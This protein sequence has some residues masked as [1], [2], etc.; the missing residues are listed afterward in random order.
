MENSDSPPPAKKSRKAGRLQQSDTRLEEAILENLKGLQERRESLSLE[1]E[2]FGRQI[3]ATLQ[4]LEPRKKAMAKM[5]IQH[6]LFS[7]EFEDPAG[8]STPYMSPYNF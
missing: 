2:L 1:D 7:L 8:H 4:R 3:A 6:L 5:Q